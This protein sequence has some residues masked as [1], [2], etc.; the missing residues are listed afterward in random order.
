MRT[1]PVLVVAALT[2][3]SSKSSTPPAGGPGSG[4]AP[5]ASAPAAPGSTAAAP[6]AAAG[7][8]LD[9]EKLLPA[10]LREKY[11]AGAT[12][13]QKPMCPGCPEQCKLDTS[14]AMRSST[15]MVDCR[16]PG[17]DYVARITEQW[18][19]QLKMTKLT[20]VGR[21]AYGMK[22]MQI[23]FIPDAHDCY[24]TITALQKSDEELL[25]IAKD[26][27]AALDPSALPL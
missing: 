26:I 7:Q 15:V 10:A 4:S 19:S 13:T 18:V 14:D 6:A 21:A 5:A 24:I 22:G 25:M 8:K 17:G 3:C 16:S 11:F 2:A 23:S 9:C 27:A 1:L 20:G 12:M